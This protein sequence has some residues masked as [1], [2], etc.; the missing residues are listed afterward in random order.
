MA[1]PLTIY[2]QV[3]II[4]VI[5]A[6]TLDQAVVDGVHLARSHAPLA[7]CVAGD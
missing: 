3:L 5:A 1:L 2:S 7:L 6:I 4:P